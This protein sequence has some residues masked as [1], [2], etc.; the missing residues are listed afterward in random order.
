[1]AYLHPRYLSSQLEVCWYILRINPDHKTSENVSK[2]YH[3]GTVTSLTLG[4]PAEHL[5]WGYRSTVKKFHSETHIQ[6]YM[7]STSRSA[8]TEQNKLAVTDHTIS[9]RCHRLRSS[10]G[11]WQREQQNGT[12]G[13]KGYT[14]QQRTRQVYERRRGV[15]STITHRW[16][17]VCSNDF[18]WRMEFS[19]TIP[20]KATAIAETSTI[21]WKVVS[22]DFY[23]ASA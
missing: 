12:V 15:L 17:T 20:K 6:A 13:Q 18:Q 5:V 19:Q 9:Q 16:Q 8:A 23:S 7:R 2:K 3:A 10:Q 22:D 1:M 21:K 4:K 14:H 11:D